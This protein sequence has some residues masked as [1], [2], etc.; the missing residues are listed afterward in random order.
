MPDVGSDPE[1]ERSTASGPPLHSARLRCEV[2]GLETPH[3]ILHIEHGKPGAK[4]AVVRGVARCRTCGLSHPFVSELPRVGE[5]WLIISEGARSERR[6]VT[7]PVDRKVQ[8]GTGLPEA[9][10][11]LVIHKVEDRQGHPISVGRVREVSTIWA[12]RDVGPFVQY[13]LVEGRV[14]RAGRLPIEPE[15]MLEVGAT[16]RLPTTSATIVG[17]RARNHTWRREGDRFPA[18]EVQRLYARRTERP[19]AG[20]TDWS[21]E[22]ETPRSRASS[23]STAARSRS[24][25]GVR[26]TRT[27]PR[28]RTAD[29][30]AAVHRSSDS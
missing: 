23:T 11:P 10:E 20:R 18:G 27:D 14:T 26:R 19:P 25:P 7:L 12:V 6:R 5:V 4:A 29:S 28:A 24:S 15:A 13:S 9:S 17:L 2:C 1:R 30:G 8:L 21:T 22:R 16:V 3:R